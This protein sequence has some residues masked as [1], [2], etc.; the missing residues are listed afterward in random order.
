M[1]DADYFLDLLSSPDP[2][3]DDD[4]PSSVR[5]AS[6][7]ITKS[8]HDLSSL[9][10]P[11]SSPRRT[12]RAQ[13]PRKRTFQLDVGDERSPQRIR[14]TV[15][16]EEDLKHDGVNRKL[17]PPPSSSLRSPRRRETIT[18]TTVPLND[19]AEQP[20]GDAGTPRKRGRQRRT[21]NGTPM[22]RIRK[23]AETP[24]QRKSKRARHEDEPSSETGILNDAS[25][26]VGM[27]GGEETPKPKPK[28]RPRKTPRKPP[29]NVSV[30]SSQVSNST[31]GRKRGRPRKIPLPE[32]TTVL[33]GT[34]HETSDVDKAKTPALEPNRQHGPDGSP[35]IGGDEAASENIRDDADASHSLPS[36][37]PLATSSPLHPTSF[38]DLAK[39]NRSSGSPASSHQELAEND[40]FMMD[41]DYQGMEPQSDLSRES[42]YDGMTHH[43]QDTIADASEFSM[44]AVES[45]PSFQ[46]SFQASFHENA[47]QP[48]PEH[49]EMGEETSRIISRTLDSLRHSVKN[50]TESPSRV[51]EAEKQLKGI[52]DQDQDDEQDQ[53][54]D[55]I[56]NQSTATTNYDSERSFARSPRRLK[57]LPLSRQVFVGRGNVD[58][59][60][61][62]IPDSI[63]HAATPGRVPTE[64]A[65]GERETYGEG[66]G[67]YEDSF[68]EV[69]E[70]VLEAATPRPARRIETS[71]HL[72]PARNEEITRS[73]GRMPSLDY[74]SGRLL[75]PEETSSSNAGSRNA[76]EEDA[77]LELQEQP[78]SVHRTDVPSSPPIITRPRAL[79]FGYSA[80][81][82]ELSTVKEK[83]SS[84]PER[85]IPAN[86]TSNQP[87]S[88][89][90]PVPI[91]R[92]SL[93]PIVRAGRTLQNVM[94]DNSSPEEREVNL[95]S[96]FK[97]SASSDHPRQSSVARSPSPSI[98]KRGQPSKSR[99][100]TSSPPR[101]NQNFMA[102]FDRNFGH[103]PQRPGE[104]GDPFGQ[105]NVTHSRTGSLRE[106]IRHQPSEPV[107]FIYNSSVTGPTQ[108][109]QPSA[110]DKFGWASHDNSSQRMDRQQPSLQTGNS[111]N[112]S[113]TG[114]RTTG[115]SQVATVD[116]A[117]FHPNDNQDYY[118]EPAQNMDEDLGDRLDEQS[119]DGGDDDDIDIWD[120]E[121][122]RM[123]PDKPEPPKTVSRPIKPD[124]PPSRRSKVPSPWKRNNRRLIYKDDIASSSQIEI[125]ESSQSEMEQFPPIRPRQRPL[126]SQRQQEAQRRAPDPE[127]VQ[128]T[129]MQEELH[130]REKSGSPD[131]SHYSFGEDIGLADS[132]EPDIMEEDEEPGRPENPQEALDPMDENHDGDETQEEPEDIEMPKAPEAS[133]NISE[134]SMVTRQAKQT[135]KPQEKP[136]QPKSRFFSGFDILSFF[137][138][139][140]TLPRNKLPGSNP[141][142]SANNLV[143]V[144]PTQETRQLKEPPMALWSTGL[145][146]S[147]PQKGP[148]P[149]AGQRTDLYPPSSALRSNDT[150]ADTY[151]PSTTIS[152]SPSPSRFR[153]E[154]AAPSTPERQVL[155]P[156]QQKQDFTPRPGQSGGSL[157]G[158]KKTYSSVTRDEFNDESQESSDE[159]D[160]ALTETSEYERVPPR[161]KPST[162]DRNLSPTKSCFRSPLKPTTPGRIVA[163]SNNALSPLAQAQVRST[164]RNNA[165]IRN[166]ISQGPL[167]RPTF[168]GKENQPHPHTQQ[169]RNANDNS[170][171]ENKPRPSVAPQ[172]RPQP[173]ATAPTAPI[174]GLSQT[175]WSRQHW[176]RLDEL[177]QLRRRDP[178]RF[179]QACALPPRDKRRSTALLGK[180]VLAQDARLVL[181]PWHLDVVEAFKLKVGGWDERVLAKR[182]FALVI[183][184]EKRRAAAA[185]AAPL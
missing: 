134:Y 162:W 18:T 84:S 132:D 177:I 58:E 115:A 14:V 137:S 181:E 24:M 128:K 40:D 112:Q 32:E 127:P 103:A 4:V 28:P 57:P 147:I 22:P 139:P 91:V 34:G 109:D 31:T 118:D 133:I 107:P 105:N 92:P 157:F 167:L 61:S 150:I 159:Q 106:S 52:E 26:D 185:T 33:A 90:A 42:E 8:Q 164:L 68:S 174:V 96:P 149:S 144:Q 46:A 56:Q 135:P 163:F 83:Q 130:D 124:V 125:E 88:L 122:S 2:L 55:E 117:D 77:G 44:I 19:G 98:R 27:D 184:G 3:A 16:A 160:S 50:M 136:A 48:A 99:L 11:K 161:E 45:L 138:S 37:N 116:A 64:R 97:G 63:L 126:A 7:R 6:R 166:T 1:A 85:H 120:I 89:E 175:A 70:A 35:S 29:A 53:I 168:E 140:A 15:E 121:A 47:G 20:D 113:T 13:S 152:P 154:S 129:Q 82:R 25:A 12:S 165:N 75:T 81:Q 182:V 148:Q 17:F 123:S 153:S 59:S 51:A 114:S 79:D 142:S 173:H 71:T 5:P 119:N 143:A 78:G 43:G 93:S 9:T 156:I 60:F 145:F 151:E 86:T 80:L 172:A 104:I 49:S 108:V 41:E 23:R 155:P 65:T 62:T 74:G 66:D 179:Q 21:S 30:P 178:L 39:I 131:P 183:G 102:N 87:H 95:G 180:E 111:H 146:P 176:C 36:R 170:L 158:H 110:D 100:P 76:Q 171:D 72:S 94:S 54:R 141:T 69:P 10:I 73:I 101:L 38:Q 169:I 67:A